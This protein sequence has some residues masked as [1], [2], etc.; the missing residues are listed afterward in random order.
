MTQ[1]ST[2][3][4]LPNVGTYKCQHEYAAC[5]WQ[6]ISGL[7]ENP[8]AA[9]VWCYVVLFCSSAICMTIISQHQSGWQPPGEPPTDPY[10]IVLSSINTLTSLSSYVPTFKHFEDRGGERKD[11]FIA[12]WYSS[13]ELLLTWARKCYVWCPCSHHP[14]HVNG[15]A[16]DG[17]HQSCPR[18]AYHLWLHLGIVSEFPL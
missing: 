16:G 17:E 18:K 5:T 14:G 15:S 13:A 4:L 9:F 7:S 3:Y 12:I 2:P 1:P 8:G 10:C 11:V 6:I